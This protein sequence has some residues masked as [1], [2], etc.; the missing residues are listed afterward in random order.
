MKPWQKTVLWIG[1]A[2]VV[3]GVI[4]YLRKKSV[5]TQIPAAQD[6]TKNNYVVWTYAIIAA[7]N[8]SA[9]YSNDLLTQLQTAWNNVEG[10]SVPIYD[11]VS[12]LAIYP[13][14]GMFP[15]P[16]TVGQISQTSGQNA[17]LQQV[18]ENACTLAAIAAKNA[19][20]QN[21]HGQAIGW[22]QGYIDTALKTI[23]QTDRNINGIPK[24]AASFLVLFNYAVTNTFPSGG[25]P[26]ADAISGV[27]SDTERNL[28]V[29]STSLA[30]ITA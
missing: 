22:R 19:I 3:G 28:G 27:M 20:Q 11:H 5:A 16:L 8:S 30:P 2:V 25:Q 1:G 21:T 15:D 10:T 17:M 24:L 29:I 12:A 7:L 9:G 23:Y 14:N 26:T 4:Y 18:F 6:P 13:T